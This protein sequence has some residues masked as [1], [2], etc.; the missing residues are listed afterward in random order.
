MGSPTGKSCEA[1]GVF[2][3]DLGKGWKLKWT[4]VENKVDSGGNEVDS[5]EQ[6]P[7]DRLPR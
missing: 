5:D 2:T 3:G 1:D 7:I 6:R 4:R